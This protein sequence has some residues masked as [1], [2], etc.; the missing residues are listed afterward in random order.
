M[1]IKTKYEVEV[2]P[3]NFDNSHFPT[4]DF[5]KSIVDRYFDKNPFSKPRA[6]SE[7]LLHL[8]AVKNHDYITSASNALQGLIERRIE[9][10]EK[11]D[12]RTLHSAEAI[13]R[14]D[15]S[16]DITFPLI[17]DLTK[18]PEETRSMFKK[19]Q[20]K[21]IFFFEDLNKQFTPHRIT[22]LMTAIM[23][24]NKVVIDLLINAKVDTNV[25][26]I[27]QWTALHHAAAQGDIETI[28]KLLKAGANPKLRND[29]RGTYDDILT[30]VG[31]KQSKLETFKIDL[32]DEKGKTT[33]DFKQLTGA[34]YTETL[35]IN[36]DEFLND[37]ASLSHPVPVTNDKMTSIREQ[38]EQVYKN[39]SWPL[40]QLVKLTRT[41]DG[42]E[43]PKGFGYGVI[44]GKDIKKGDLI[45]EYAGDVVK[46][47]D[48]LDD[49]IYLMRHID[50]KKHRSLGP[51][52]ADGFPNVAQVCLSNTHGWGE[53]IVLQACE[54]IPEGNSLYIDYTTDDIKL[55]DYVIPNLNEM[56]TFFE[57]HPVIN[58]LD[59]LK[60]HPDEMQ[61][62][63]T[64]GFNYAAKLGYLLH[65]PAA[66]I[67]LILTERVTISELENAYNLF[68]NFIKI[69]LQ[70]NRDNMISALKD[71]KGNTPDVPRSAISDKLIVLI[72]ESKLTLAFNL[73]LN[74]IPKIL[75]VC[76]I[77]KQKAPS[78]VTPEIYK[79]LCGEVVEIEATN[80]KNKIEEKNTTETK[81][82]L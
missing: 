14:N 70:G 4:E 69:D 9:L 20:D 75:R 10:E 63:K 39:R 74:C 50:G 41:D 24:G 29:R 59:Y 60:K 15:E 80:M 78:F 38:Y 7:L 36:K 53:V 62:P 73:L 54:D 66:I 34:E 21:L 2:M 55:N 76:S 58:M 12:L 48:D 1:N 32:V 25:A 5:V 52:I 68:D 16:N 8:C 82:T 51:M 19:A 17:L 72:L 35:L 22:P 6:R 43:I 64:S 31:A 42:R 61:T 37:W 30:L 81:F 67:Y 45:C 47:I 3:K 33:I 26:D 49:K 11:V 56:V 13:V 71:L 27:H 18:M 23:F 77:M 65:T 79:E 46:N 28:K 44:A 57:Q 40:L